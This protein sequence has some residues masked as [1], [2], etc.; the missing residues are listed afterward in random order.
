MKEAAV[1]S[2]RTTLAGV[3]QFVGVLG[4]ALHH[5]FDGVDSTT[6]EWGLVFAS[7]VIL[8]GLITARD[9]NVSSEEAGVSK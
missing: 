7:A 6:P 4:T 2:W 1:S 9:N 3:G 8:V 5:H